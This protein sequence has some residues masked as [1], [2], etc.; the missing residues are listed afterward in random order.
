MPEIDEGFVDAVLA[1]EAADI[2]PAEVP[3]EVEPEPD[4]LD[5]LSPS[6][7]E[8]IRKARD[9]AASRRVEHKPY[10]E[11][12]SQFNEDEQKYLLDVVRM[13][14]GSDAEQRA[15][16][17]EFKRLSDVLSG[18][19][20][21]EEAVASA[22]EEK[23]P[24]V[25][26]P[27]Q[28]VPSADDIRKMIEDAINQDRGQRQQEKIMED[29]VKKIVAEAK[30]L[31]FEKGTPQYNFLMNAAR[32]NGGDLKAAAEEFHSML[33]APAEESSTN[34]PTSPTAVGTPPPTSGKPE[35]VGDTKKTSEALRQW[36]DSRPG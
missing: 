19:E 35:W 22:T 7:Q 31:G 9:E 15:A 27:T 21:P 23:A 11:A 16:A 28:S 12:F 34:W 17:A 8:M 26:A 5:D 13:A 25:E 2:P 3:P 4:S 36:L 24:K 10:K 20:S 18:E 6:A 32:A 14:G 1:S 29:Q 30:E 33:K